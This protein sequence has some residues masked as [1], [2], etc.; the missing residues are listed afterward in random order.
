PASS[1]ALC[2][3]ML[4]RPPRSTLF[5]YTTLFRSIK[6]YAILG[7]H[8]YGDYSQ[9]KSKKDK[10]ENF[11]AIKQFYAENNFKL[12]LNESENIEKENQKI[13]IIGVENW[14]HPPFK[15]YGDLQKALQ[16]T[17]DIPFKIL[18]S[19][20]PSHWNAQVTDQTNIALTLSGHTHGMQAAFKLKNKEWS[21]IKYKY[22]QW[23][24]LY[25][26]HQK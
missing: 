26:H 4:R 25:N 13:A 2:A 22:K 6:K 12:L 16:N 11:N 14:G 21:P 24:G 19:H 23:A 10:Q 17:K 8:D 15:Q 1:T 5:P 3:S 9:W 20:D 18:L 7:N